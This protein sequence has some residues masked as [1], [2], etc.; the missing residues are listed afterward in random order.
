VISTQQNRMSLAASYAIQIAQ[1]QGES[2][3][4]PDHLLLGCLL[5]LSRFGVAAIG[6]WT[7][8]LDPLG[9]DWMRADWLD[10]Q[11]TSTPKVAYSDSAVA[12]FDRTARI[13][14]LD[15]S[16]EL[17][18]EH[19]LAAFAGEEA[20]L[21]GQLKHKFAI[22]SAAWRAAAARLNT[23]NGTQA[24]T[25]RTE[26]AHNE[27]GAR[28]YLTPE[29]AAEALDIH[30]QTLRAYVRSG[31]LPAFRLAGERSLRIRRADLHKVLEPLAPEKRTTVPTEE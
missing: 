3:V 20:G 27:P 16:T 26:E 21:M 23:T 15:G 1:L 11:K 6:P 14:R 29:L 17:R 4:G 30:V 7:I 2:E 28:D 25:T 12:L 22:D 13:A 31:K 19:M 18:V 24:E 8:D 5:A 10:A 9:V